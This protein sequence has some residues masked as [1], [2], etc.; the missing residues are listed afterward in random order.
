M[1]RLTRETGIQHHVDHVIPL[2]GRLVSGLHVVENLRVIPGK[3]NLAKNSK[4]TP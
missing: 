3:E 2:K 4:F 1:H